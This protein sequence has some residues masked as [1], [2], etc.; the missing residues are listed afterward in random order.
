MGA[1]ISAFFPGGL[2][3]KGSYVI[4]LAP[5]ISKY[6]SLRDPDKAGEEEFYDT[7]Y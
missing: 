7:V 5:Y 2:R 4:D 1:P 6:Y 3:Y